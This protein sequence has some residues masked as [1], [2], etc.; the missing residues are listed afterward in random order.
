MKKNISNLSS[1]SISKARSLLS[2]FP[3]YNSVMKRSAKKGLYST[4]NIIMI[5]YK[6]TDL[7][8]LFFMLIFIPYP[9]FDL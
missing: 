5:K 7:S 2:V 1:G 4:N 6:M 3:S 9:S 8:S